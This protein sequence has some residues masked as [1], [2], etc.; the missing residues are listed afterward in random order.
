M[1]DYPLCFDANPLNNK[2]A[3]DSWH[4]YCKV[5]DSKKAANPG[6]PQIKD[7]HIYSNGHIEKMTEVLKDRRA[8]MKILNNW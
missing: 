2:G 8:L 4:V 1:L 6:T 7:S 5:C 3:Y